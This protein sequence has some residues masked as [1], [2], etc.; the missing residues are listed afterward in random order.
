[1][2]PGGACPPAASR[3]HPLLPTHPG[4]GSQARNSGRKQASLQRRVTED[5][6]WK[7]EEAPK[8]GRRTS[9]VSQLGSPGQFL[10]KKPD[11]DS[12]GDNRKPGWA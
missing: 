4:E 11:L 9:L 1:M 10:T 12:V 8:R 7:N 6:I 5:G 3:L 2:A